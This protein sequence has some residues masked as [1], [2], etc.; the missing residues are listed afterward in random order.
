MGA[1]KE[2]PGKSI[3]VLGSGD[4]LRTTLIPNGL[5]DEYILLIHPLILGTG[6]RL[7]E[8]SLGPATLSLIDSL[9]TDTGVLIATYR[10]RS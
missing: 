10:P 4:L 6:Q 9:P 8:P 5:V 2:R 7:F 3:V 1:L